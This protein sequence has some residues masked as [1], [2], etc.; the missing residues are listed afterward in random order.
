VLRRTV[1][2]ASSKTISGRQVSS[3]EKLNA[4]HELLCFAIDKFFPLKSYKKNQT[5]KP[6]II[7]ELKILVEQRQQA[8]SKDPATFKRLRNKVNKL[9]NGLRRSFFERGVKNCDNSAF[10][11]VY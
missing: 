10:V 2:Q 9:N 1:N 5:D 6:W 7:L 3:T 4:F 8:I 11:E